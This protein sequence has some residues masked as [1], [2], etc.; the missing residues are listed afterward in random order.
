MKWFKH[1]SDALNDPKIKSLKFKYGMEGYGIYFGLLELI[2]RDV[3]DDLDNV[4]L[5]SEDWS[6]D[7]LLGEF[8]VSSDKLREVFSYMSKVG[9]IIEEN[10]SI[11]I[12]KIAERTDDYVS[13]LLRNEGKK[14]SSPNIVRTKSNK[15]VLEQNRIDKN[16]IDNKETIKEKKSLDY[17]RSEEGHNEI[18]EK[19]PDCKK[20]DLDVEIEKAID[21]LKSKG[22]VQ[23]DN[24]AFM[25]NWIRKA[26]KDGNVA[27]QMVGSPAVREEEV[28]FVA[29]DPEKWRDSRRQMIDHPD[30]EK[31]YPE[32]FDKANKEIEMSDQEI[33]D[34]ED[35]N[36]SSIIRANIKM[37]NV[38]KEI[39]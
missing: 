8:G 33:I 16:R 37:R 19:F 5:L 21:W 34:Y 28:V 30:F 36:I 11:R 32:L 27:F 24:M 7:L 31:Q 39:G 29:R 20:K 4:G 3:E 26:V 10:G 12:P 38:V 35:L 22:R 15:V 2:A 14:E 18:Y 6:D 13:R 9:L 23:K 25:R 1:D 17:L